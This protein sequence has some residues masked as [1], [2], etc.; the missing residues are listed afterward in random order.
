MMKTNILLETGTNELE[1]I[2]FMVSFTNQAGETVEQSY[3]INVAKVREIIRMPDITVL[4]NMPESIVGVFNM[5]NN[6]ITAIDVRKYLYKSYNQSNNR[7]MIIAEFNNLRFGFI[8]DMVTRI[9]RFSWQQVEEPGVVNQFAGNN[10]TIVGIVKLP[11]KNILLLDVEKI[12]V[13]LQP[14]LGIQNVEQHLV[15]TMAGKTAWI[16]D[17]SPTIRQMI[18]SQLRNA[19]FAIEAFSDGASAWQR[20]E[21]F[22]CE[23]AQN[24]ELKLPDIIITDIEMPQMDGYSLTRRIKTH[25][26]LGSIPV[27]LFSSLVNEDVIHKGQAVGAE[28][29]LTKPQLTELL[30]H[31]QA[32]FDRRLAAV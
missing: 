32:V 24:P 30:K 21:K 16:A 27:A 11:E 31:I 6:I 19:G 22:I 20:C 29:Q 1:I 9:Y 25:P 26:M 13:D 12:I 15:G 17:D 3:G 28:V 14:E 7:T 4:P 5:R 18:V 23:K 10:A 8:V 2:E